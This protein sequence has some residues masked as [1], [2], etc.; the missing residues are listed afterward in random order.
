MHV[1]FKYSETLALTTWHSVLQHA[2]TEQN[3]FQ[4]RKSISWLVFQVF[5]ASLAALTWKWLEQD[6]WEWAKRDMESLVE[7]WELKLTWGNLGGNWAAKPDSSHRVKCRPAWLQCGLLAEENRHRGTVKIVHFI[8]LFS[9]IDP[10]AKAQW[11]CCLSNGDDLFYMQTS[12]EK[13]GKK[14]SHSCKDSY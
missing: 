7:G 9:W 4:G 3:I 5:T 1:L 13:K 14:L 2:D 10:I 6:A 12:G 8:S 11:G